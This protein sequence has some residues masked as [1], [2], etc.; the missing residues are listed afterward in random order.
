MLA[1][2][3]A[4][5]ASLLLAEESPTPGNLETV[6]AGLRYDLAVEVIETL[7]DAA[8]LTQ[9][10]LKRREIWQ[11]ALVGRLQAVAQ[12]ATPLQIPDDRVASLRASLEVLETGRLHPI[13]TYV[14]DGSGADGLQGLTL[15][16]VAALRLPVTIAR[17]ERLAACAALS[18]NYARIWCE[19]MVL[20][21]AHPACADPT[22]APICRTAALPSLAFEMSRSSRDLDLLMAAMFADRHGQALDCTTAL[23]PE[24]VQTCRAVQARDA[25]LCPPWRA[26]SATQ[27]SE[28]TRRPAE[29]LSDLDL[30]LGVRRDPETNSVLVAFLGDVPVDCRVF[31]QPASG[32]LRDLATFSKPASGRR[33]AL[34][35]LVPDLPPGPGVLRAECR[36]GSPPIGGSLE[37]PANPRASERAF[38]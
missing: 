30:A 10:S 1:T 35:P 33:V 25:A 15:E 31:E 20:G 21:E 13:C 3:I 26:F 32:A 12:A 28:F 6:V 37:A 36:V 5:F 27:V 18:R 17:S 38:P 2:W 14:I 7:D 34:E 24:T 16:M 29:L 23:A 11:K 9:D 8:A 22:V 4:L 19:A